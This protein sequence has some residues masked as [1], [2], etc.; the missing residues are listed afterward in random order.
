[1]LVRL[2]ESVGSKGLESSVGKLP[3]GENRVVCVGRMPTKPESELDRKIE[4]QVWRINPKA[5]RQSW[6]IPV[7]VRIV[8]TAECR[9]QNYPVSSTSC[10]SCTTL[11]MTGAKALRVP[12]NGEY[13]LAKSHANVLFSEHG[14][15]VRNR[16]SNGF[17]TFDSEN[18]IRPY[19][20][21][22]L[23]HIKILDI[24][25]ADEPTTTA[26][27]THYFIR[28]DRFTERGSNISRVGGAVGGGSHFDNIVRVVSFILRNH[29]DV[30]Q[31]SHS[32]SPILAPS[33]PQSRKYCQTMPDAAEASSRTGE[34]TSQQVSDAYIETHLYS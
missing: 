34:E 10:T 9:S 29:Q 17:S 22:E 25:V 5:N 2:T 11:S 19:R 24:S 14:S 30:I 31:D 20:S 4:I 8:E 1:M 27:T 12:G 13:S 28:S 26:R 15:K 32:P 3:E 16:P 33:I 21:W 6:H 7:A 18:Y 23:H